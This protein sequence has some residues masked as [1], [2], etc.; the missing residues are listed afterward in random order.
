MY[1][2]SPELEIAHGIYKTLLEGLYFIASTKHIDTRG[3]YSELV[4]IPELEQVRG[5]PFTVAQVNI[6]RSYAKV[7]RGIHAENWNKLVTVTQGT[8]FCAFADIRPQSS[9][10]KQV[11]TV[12]LGHGE[13]ALHGSFF[14][15]KGIGNSL[16]VIEGP[17]DYLYYVDELYKERD[18]SFDQAVSLFDPELAIQWPL[19]QAEMI[20]SDRDTKAISLAELVRVKHA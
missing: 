11:E 2:P 16:C 18:T 1:S 15:E 14:I 20:I 9:T 17:V 19:T 4:R 13:N 8:A 7:A 6:A 3:Y 5:V 10:F 12:L